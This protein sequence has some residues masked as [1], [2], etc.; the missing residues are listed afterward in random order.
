MSLTATTVPIGATWA[1]PVDGTATALKSLGSTLSSNKLYLDDGSALV[2]QKQFEVT[3]KSPVPLAS[4]PNGYSQ[5]R[6]KVYFK[7]PKL[8][9]NGNYTVNTVSVEIAYDPE[10]TA[11]EIAALREIASIIGAHSNFD[12]LVEDGSTSS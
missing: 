5:Q 7:S 10:T 1:I 11:S 9:A 3:A 4:A 8:L 2:L 6:A 12:E